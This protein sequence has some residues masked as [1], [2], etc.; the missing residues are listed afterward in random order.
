MNKNGQK[1]SV[2]SCARPAPTSALAQCFLPHVPVLLHCEE[3]DI[4]A[5]QKGAT[6]MV[7]EHDFRTKMN[8][9]EVS[10][11][12]RQ[13]YW[14]RFCSSTKTEG[15]L[16]APYMLEIKG[17]A[18]LWPQ[19]HHERCYSSGGREQPEVVLDMLDENKPRQAQVWHRRR[20]APGAARV[21]FENSK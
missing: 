2:L 4:A 17:V 20:D 1:A 5:M 7:G 9:A 19:L 16:A 13:I 14:P 15:T 8:V 10:N 12:Q 21:L 3:S 6:F 11:F 18:F